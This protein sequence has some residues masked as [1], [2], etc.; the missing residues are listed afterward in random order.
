MPAVAGGSAYSGAVS[1]PRTP[2]PP[3]QPGSPL[4]WAAATGA[5]LV[6][7]ALIATLAT[8]V[9]RLVGGG[10]LGWLAG[11]AA[12]IALV[13]VWSRWM[14]PRAPRRLAL[15]GRLVLGCALVLAAAGL[16]HLAGM[17]AW[18]AWFAGLGV[19]LTVA[20]QSLTGQSLEPPTSS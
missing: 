19:L 8:A 14:S 12:V 2:E 9:H 1:R 11:G 6:E 3:A 10:V 15:V 20:G 18:A 5:F 13:A 4:A 16:A 17:S 7:L